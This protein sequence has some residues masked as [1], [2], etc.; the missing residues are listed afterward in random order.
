MTTNKMDHGIL[1]SFCFLKNRIGSA[2]VEETALDWTRNM[3][4]C[5]KGRHINFLFVMVRTQWEPFYVIDKTT[6]DRA[7]IIKK[8]MTV[9]K[10]IVTTLTIDIIYIYGLR[11]SSKCLFSWFQCMFCIVRVNIMSQFCGNWWLCCIRNHQ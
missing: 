4:A 7:I 10:W 1:L 11:N 8:L 9:L 2:F 3:S 6:Y 5:I